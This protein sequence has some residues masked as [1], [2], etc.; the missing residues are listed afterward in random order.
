MEA[1]REEAVGPAEKGEEKEEESEKGGES[2][3]AERAG[4]EVPR[5]GRR[6]V[7]KEGKEVG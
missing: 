5:L 1:R 4:K 3:E 7:G 2:R 6:E